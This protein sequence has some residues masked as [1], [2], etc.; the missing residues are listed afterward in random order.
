MSNTELFK[1][2]TIEERKCWAQ[3]A[4]DAYRQAKGGP[5]PDEP[6]NDVSD[7]LADLLH[8]IVGMPVNE[9]EAELACAQAIKHYIA[10]CS[11]LL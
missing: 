2:I 8:I 11:S 3:A 4:V 1:P 5:D 9:A 10:E 7:L 6:E